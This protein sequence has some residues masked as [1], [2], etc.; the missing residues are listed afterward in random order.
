MLTV[1]VETHFWASHQLTLPDGSKEPVHS[2]NWSVTADIGS[3]MPNNMGLVMDFRRLKAMLDNIVAEFDNVT[4]DSIDY[5]GQNNSTAE[6]VAR[7]I[8]EKLQPGLPKD[9][10]LEAISVTEEPGCLAKFTG[11]Y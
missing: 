3:D 11:P 10:K 7:Y 9:V 8:Y 4:L 1:S 5:F 6:N 2:H